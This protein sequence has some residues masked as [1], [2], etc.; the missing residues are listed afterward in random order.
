MHGQSQIV[1]V[2]IQLGVVPRPSDELIHGL[3]LQVASR[4]EIVEAYGRHIQETVRV[5]PVT[6]EEVVTS[7]YLPFGRD[8]IAAL[9][10]ASQIAI[11]LIN[12]LPFGE[13]HLHVIELGTDIE[14]VP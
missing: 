6:V 3:E 8:E 12:L 2:S 14:A 1:V 11:G 13:A 5:H 10:I 7:R 4:E 9:H